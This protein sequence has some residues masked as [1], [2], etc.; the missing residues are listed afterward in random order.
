MCHA[1]EVLEMFE[2]EMLP[3][4]ENNVERILN[5][6]VWVNLLNVHVYKMKIVTSM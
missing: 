2:I 4:P 3:L 5:K 6:Y 1:A